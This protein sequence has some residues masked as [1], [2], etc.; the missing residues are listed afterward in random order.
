MH[1]LLYYPGTFSRDEATLIKFDK[2]KEIKN[3]DI[4]LKKDGG[5]IL[6]GTVTDEEGKPV[7]QAFVVV[8][9]SDMLFDFS[10]AYT[11]ENGHYKIDALGPGNFLA[12]VD[13]VHKGYVRTRMPFEIKAG[14][15]ELT[16]N[17]KL[18]RGVSISGKFVDENGNEWKNLNGYGNVYVSNESVK[19][20]NSLSSFSLTNFRNKYRP[21]DS[22]RGS[23]GYFAQGQGDYNNGEMIFP[24]SGTFVFQ[25]MMPGKTKISFEPKEE[26]SSVKEILY[27]G[28]NIKDTGLETSP[29]QEIKDVTIVIAK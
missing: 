1:I 9:H 18:N 29:G 4:K 8:H 26:G 25:G 6:A 2:E 17:F 5:I 24:T 15:K 20:T 12:H 3:I 13:A 23:G 16:M 28:Q 22:R 21:K 14:D 11:D 19:D 7:S 27:N 10:T